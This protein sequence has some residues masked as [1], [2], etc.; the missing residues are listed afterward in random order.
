MKR[1]Y[2]LCYKRLSGRYLHI[3]NK[4]IEEAVGEHYQYIEVIETM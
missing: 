3:H 2:E 4:Y 1:A